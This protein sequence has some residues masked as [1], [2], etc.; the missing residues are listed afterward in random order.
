MIGKLHFEKFLRLDNIK[1]VQ[2]VKNNPEYYKYWKKEINKNKPSI[3]SK[4]LSSD[5][6]FEF[7]RDE[8]NKLYIIYNKN[9]I[10]ETIA[11]FCFNCRKLIND[12]KVIWEKLNEIV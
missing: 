2:R 3:L 8:K 5:S 10:N 12:I 7:V 1:R 9:K 4:T 6:E 11:W